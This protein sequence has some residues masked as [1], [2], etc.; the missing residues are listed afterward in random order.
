MFSITDKNKLCFTNN[1]RQTF[2]KKQK[3]LD[4]KI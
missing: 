2:I 3:K 1:I 4:F